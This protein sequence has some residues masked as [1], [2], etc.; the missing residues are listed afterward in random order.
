MLACVVSYS[1]CLHRDVLLP[2]VHTVLA[3]HCALLRLVVC[4]L[5]DTVPG[6]AQVPLRVWPPPLELHEGLL[7]H[8]GESLFTLEML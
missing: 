4:G 8:P 6:G 3:D 2:P 7:P 1:P 5:G